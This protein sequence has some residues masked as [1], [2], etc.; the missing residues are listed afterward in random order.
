MGGNDISVAEDAY[1]IV[2][3]GLRIKHTDIKIEKSEI[4]RAHSVFTRIQEYVHANHP[5]GV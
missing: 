2:P 5:Q 1:D 3:P 4:L